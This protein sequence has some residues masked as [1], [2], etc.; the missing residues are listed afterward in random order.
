MGKLPY[1]IILLVF[2]KVLAY[3]FANA[4]YCCTYRHDSS[5]SE[6]SDDPY[7]IPP[8]DNNSAIKHCEDS[9]KFLK[10]LVSDTEIEQYFPI[11]ESVIELSGNIQTKIG[12]LIFE[13][14]VSP[15]LCV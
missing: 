5:Y 12:L 6:S 2:F 14:D 1:I 4:G 11:V 15:P 3:N 10:L 7:D 13:S 8:I 9:G